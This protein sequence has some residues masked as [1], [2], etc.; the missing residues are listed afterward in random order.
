MENFKKLED[1]AI[2]TASDVYVTE[3]GNITHVR[4]MSA[5]NERA[6]IKKIDKNSYIV[7]SECNPCPEALN[8]A[9]VIQYKDKNDGTIKPYILHHYDTEKKGNR[10]DNISELK[11]T[12]SKLRNV[13]NANATK[14]Q[15]IR[16]CTFTYAEN[17][18]DSKKLY[19]DFRAFNQRF[20][21][22][23]AN[24]H[25]NN[26]HYEYILACE[27]QGRGAWHIHALFIFDKKAPFIQN[28][29]LHDLWGH[30]FVNIQAVKDSV[31]DLGRYFTAYLTDVELNDGEQVPQDAQVKTVNSKRYVKGGRLHMYPTGFNYF[32]CSRGIKRPNK[33]VT[34]WGEISRKL[35]PW[36]LTGKLFCQFDVV[37]KNV[38]DV[39]MPYTIKMAIFYYNTK[40]AVE[41]MN[42]LDKLFAKA[43]CLGIPIDI[44]S[45]PPLARPLQLSD[46]EEEHINGDWF[47][48]EPPLVPSNT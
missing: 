3:M 36:W 42:P 26:C 48:F 16:W 4:Y 25:P 40:R 22:Y 44:E 1:F 43:E 10:T 13:I 34:T 19:N 12:F 5:H 32:R 24:T 23:I 9:E 15:N 39:P 31:D 8:S 29:V 18:T 38:E 37:K 21:R 2:H 20:K 28:S 14:P 11:R 33:F 30:G 45:A 47:R 6:T 17:M 46:E 41:K 35:K 27:P 7:M